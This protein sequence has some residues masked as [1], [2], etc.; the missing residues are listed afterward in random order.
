M[1]VGFGS[2]TREGLAIHDHGEWG[3]ISLR[4]GLPNPNLWPLLLRDSVLYVGMTNAGVAALR[5]QPP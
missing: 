3:T 2:A 5:P 4:D 1:P